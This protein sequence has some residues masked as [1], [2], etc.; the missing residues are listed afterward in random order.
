MAHHRLGAG[1]Q[2]QRACHNS[3]YGACIGKSVDEW[4][5][6]WDSATI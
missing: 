1:D 2:S 6:G 3:H 5:S 4:T